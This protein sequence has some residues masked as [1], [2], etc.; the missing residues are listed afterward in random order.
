MIETVPSLLFAN[1]FLLHDIVTSGLRKPCNVP[2]IGTERNYLVYEQSTTDRRT[3]AFSVAP[4]SVVSNATDLCQ[5]HTQHDDSS[6]TLL[7][8]IGVNVTTLVHTYA[9]HLC[10]LE[11][12]T[13]TA[14][15]VTTGCPGIA[16]LLI[17]C[18]HGSRTRTY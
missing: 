17:A 16:K 14:S 2:K 10:A 3:L 1:T 5:C 18:T 13:C 12:D 7:A 4:Q 8:V 6:P 11:V 15:V 9:P